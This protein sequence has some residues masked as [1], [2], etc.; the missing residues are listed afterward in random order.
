MDAAVFHSIWT[1][2]LFL[3]FVG[4]LCW[5]FIVKRRSDFDQAAQIPLNDDEAHSSEE[6]EQGGHG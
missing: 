2:L 4:I 5:V 1:T 3:I 6:K